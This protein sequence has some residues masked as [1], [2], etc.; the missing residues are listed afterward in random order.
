[1][2]ITLSIIALLFI[3]GSAASEAVM[4]KLQFHYTRSIFT[5]NPSKY[6]K[7]FWDPKT[8]WVNKWK[9][10]SAKEEK[11]KGS[12]TI[13][14]FTTDAWHL[15]KFFKNTS[16]FIGLFFAILA[17]TFLTTNIFITILISVILARVVYG[18]I[19]TLFFD[20]ILEAYDPFG[21]NGKSNTPGN[22]IISTWMDD[23][24]NK[25]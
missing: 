8:S 15:F 23:V 20:N 12:S 5:K 11:F 1:M 19:F 4:D 14:V 6:N 3:I 21:T 10:S 25:K 24:N 18:V 16:M 2:I 9:D 13:F 7:L 22:E 17:G